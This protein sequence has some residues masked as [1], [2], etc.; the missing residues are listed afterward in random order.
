MIAGFE[1]PSGGD[2]RVAGVI[3][4]LPAHKR[5]IGV[6]FQQYALFPAHL[7][8]FG[9]VAYP[10]QMRRIAK[11]DITRRVSQALSMVRLDGFEGRYPRCCPAASGNASPLPGQSCSNRGCC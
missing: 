4:D 10:L 11:P 1:H 3:V 5:D 9:N 8:V 7:T 2:V 6:V